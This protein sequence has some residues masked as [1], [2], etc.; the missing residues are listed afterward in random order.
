MSEQ[1]AIP[2]PHCGGELY[3]SV[4]KFQNTTT[5]EWSECSWCSTCWLC[6]KTHDVHE[7]DP[8][9]GEEIPDEV[10]EA[11]SKVTA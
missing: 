9:E 11:R 10:R 7:P 3:D 8:W 2:C 5:G 6:I 1:V 4:T